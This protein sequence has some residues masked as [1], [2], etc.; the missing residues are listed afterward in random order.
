[1]EG[2]VR[3]QTASGWENAKVTMIT[4]ILG[5]NVIVNLWLVLQQKE[6]KHNKQTLVSLFCERIWNSLDTACLTEF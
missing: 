1:M 6:E 5:S 2:N 3:F 4:F